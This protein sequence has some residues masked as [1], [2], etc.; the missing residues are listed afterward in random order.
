ME[1]FKKAQIPE[2]DKETRNLVLFPKL[3]SNEEYD[4][5]LME[6]FH[7]KNPSNVNKK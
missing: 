6:K 1:D 2:K 7:W 5:E 3:K 4:Y